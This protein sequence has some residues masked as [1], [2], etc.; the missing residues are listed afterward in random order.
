MQYNEMA[1]SLSKSEKT[2]ENFPEYAE[3]SKDIM[4]GYNNTIHETIEANNINAQNR[5]ELRKEIMQTIQNMI[6]EDDLSTDDKKFLVDK[7][8]ENADKSDIEDRENKAFLQETQDKHGDTSLKAILLGLL[9]ASGA[10][11]TA[12]GAFYIRKKLLR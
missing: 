4:H 10:A 5:Y 1:Q 6:N 3:Y 7:M 2:M 8:M 9:I 11:G 12:I